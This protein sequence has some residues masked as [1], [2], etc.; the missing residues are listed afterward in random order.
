MKKNSAKSLER[1]SD[2]T[3]DPQ[4]ANAH[5]QRGMGML[6][7]SLRQYGAGRS[8]LVDKKG[9]II[10]GNGVIETAA[11]IGWNDDNVVIVPTSGDQIVI[12][13]RTDLDLSSPDNRAREL[14]LRDNRVAEANLTW[15]VDMLAAYAAQGVDLA[16][17]WT[18]EE[19]EA[20]LKGVEPSKPDAGAGGDD[21]T[22]GKDPEQTRVKK[23]DLWH[24]G[25][26]RMLVADSTDPA[27]VRLLMGEDAADMVFTDP[28][29]GV[30]YVGKTADALTIQNDG[31]DDAA[32]RRLIASAISAWPLKPG[33]SFYIC[34]PAGN[35]ETAFRMAVMDAAYELRQCL[36]WIKN[37]FVMGRQDY[38]W[39]HESILYGWRAGAAHYFVDDRTQ[40]TTWEF[41][42]PAASE[43]HPTMKPIGI[44]EKAIQNSTDGP[45]IVFDGFAGSGSTII[46]ANRQGRRCRAME[47][48]PVYGEVCLR[49]YEEETGETA[50]LLHRNKGEN[51]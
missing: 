50:T 22:T 18:E 49:R 9:V 14:A 40:D 32:T 45:G 33:G 10:A 28:P 51:E 17:L 19:L 12:V 5:S 25:P 30:D 29:Y 8:V 3:T 16:P 31:H 20:L 48:D 34:S 38:H 41:D 23:G 15:D 11:A 7:E 27:A 24:L 42:R 46:A 1:L 44:M 47:I 13:Q 6:E 21:T 4:N 43:L 36:V 35:T 37:H 2:L 39:A 26:H